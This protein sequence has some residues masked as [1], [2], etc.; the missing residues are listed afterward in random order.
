[1]SPLYSDRIYLSLVLCVAQHQLKRLRLT[2][3]TVNTY[4]TDDIFSSI[5]LRDRFYNFSAKLL[6]ET[7]HTHAL[8]I[9]LSLIC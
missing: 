6:T 2:I 5:K 7:L 9:V 3:Y 4:F 1:M 8:F